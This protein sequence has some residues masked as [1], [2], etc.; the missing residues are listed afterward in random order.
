MVYL[1]SC[2]KA[3][4]GGLPI[5]FSDTSTFHEAYP[6]I[7]QLRHFFKIPVY[8]YKENLCLKLLTQ[9]SNHLNETCYT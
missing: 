2:N 4:I 3:G 8:T 6:T 7:L 1:I 5:T 9:F